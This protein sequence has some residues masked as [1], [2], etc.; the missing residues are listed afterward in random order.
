MS[1][2]KREF[3]PNAVTAMTRDSERSTCP[4]HA[5][6][7]RVMKAINKILRKNEL[8][9]L[10]YLCRKICSQVMCNSPEVSV[11]EPVTWLPDRVLTL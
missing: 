9:P 3:S 2:I 10:L 11:S 8:P 7:R 6:I 5:N 1:V 4:T